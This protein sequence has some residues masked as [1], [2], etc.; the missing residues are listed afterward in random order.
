MSEICAEFESVG[1]FKD[2]APAR[3]LLE[4]LEAEFERIRPALIAELR[5]EIQEIHM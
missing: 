1:V 2:L 3:E 4:R 5:S